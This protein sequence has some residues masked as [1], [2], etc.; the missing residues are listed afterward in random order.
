MQE[1]LDHGSRAGSEPHHAHNWALG[2]EDRAGP[3]GAEP[4]APS[5]QALMQINPDILKSIQVNEPQGEPAF[6]HH[7]WPECN[8]W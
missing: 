5:L 4:P 6:Q 8:T 1:G 3:S 7:C 2:Q